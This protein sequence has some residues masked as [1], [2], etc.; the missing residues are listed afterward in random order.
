MMP[1]MAAGYYDLDH[2]DVPGASTTLNIVRQIGAS[3]ATALF[4]VILDRQIVAR[5]GSPHGSS[6]GFTLSD[7]V[8]LPPAVA[9]KVA[10]AFAHTYWWAVAT[11][12]IAFVPT[13]L[14]P[15]KAPDPGPRAAGD[16]T[17]EAAHSPIAV[18][19]E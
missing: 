3:V 2:A 6:S 12:L 1:I 7:T 14:L 8:K 13:L 17:D 18:L 16:V 5:L 19:S 10:Y 9:E 11:I 15:N 4:A